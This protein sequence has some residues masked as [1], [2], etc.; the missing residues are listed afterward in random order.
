MSLAISCPLCGC[1]HGSASCQYSPNVSGT[2]PT[3]TAR[4]RAEGESQ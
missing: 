2:F 1:V 3:P 4:E